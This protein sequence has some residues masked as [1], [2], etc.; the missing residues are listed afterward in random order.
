MTDK[1]NETAEDHKKTCDMCQ[2]YPANT[3]SIDCV[4]NFSLQQHYPKLYAAVL[5]LS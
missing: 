2:Q 5:I 1:T 4:E 3:F